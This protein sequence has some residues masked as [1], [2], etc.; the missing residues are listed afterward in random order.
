MPASVW[1][2]AK[3]PDYRVVVPEGAASW[4]VKLTT[5]AGE[6][7]LAIQQHTPPS[8]A[9]RPG[10]TDTLWYPTRN[11]GAGGQMMQ[12]A[13]NEH[14]VLLPE[15][16]ESFIPSGPYYLVVVSE[17]VNPAD[18]WHIGTASSDYLLQSLGEAPVVSLGDTEAGPLTHANN[19]EGGDLALYAF[20]VPSGTLALEARLA[21]RQGN[22][23][24][25]LRPGDEITYHYE[26]YSFNL[27]GYYGVE[28]G[29]NSGILGDSV[30]ITIP[31]PESGPYRLAVKARSTDDEHTFPDTAYTLQVRSLPI[32]ELNFD[33]RFNT[34]GGSHSASALLADNQRAF[35]RIEVPESIAGEPVLGWKLNMSQ[36]QG[37]ALVRVRKDA[38]PA[39]N[40][41]RT[42]PF[43]LSAAVIVPPYLE[44]GTWLHR[45]ERR[46]RHGVRADEQRALAG[47]AGV[48]HA[49]TGATCHHAW[50][51]G[52]GICRQRH[53]C[54]RA[55][56]GR[57]PRHLFGGR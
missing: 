56:T 21:D 20:T 51:D 29:Y 54:R 53:R 43:A 55:T 27:L 40:A 28:G 44:S 52:A 24:L 8:S 19:L 14:F 57:R 50:F 41:P 11:W 35:Y 23:V 46:R 37:R 25:A 47:T 17:G 18:D 3:R 1:S 16:G 26:F 39:D 48:V 36:T 2:L 42:T 32:P 38:L 31:N 7:L 33:S 15:E 12:K 45:S 9:V 5:T 4:N 10:T 34:N 6:A 49:G 13:G 30:A 22:P